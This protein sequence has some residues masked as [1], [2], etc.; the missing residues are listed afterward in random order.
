MPDVKGAACCGGHGNI[1]AGVS[2]RD[3]SESEN[4]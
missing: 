1:A 3:M 4:E 2:R